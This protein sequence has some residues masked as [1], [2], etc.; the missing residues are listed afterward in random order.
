MSHKQKPLYYIVKM[1]NVNVR[2]PW[3]AGEKINQI[4][5]LA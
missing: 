5:T 3:E 1:Q 4:Q 2:K